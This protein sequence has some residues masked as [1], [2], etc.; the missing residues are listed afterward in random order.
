[1]ALGG[2]GQRSCDGGGRSRAAGRESYGLG[3]GGAGLG[4]DFVRG[5]LPGQHLF[6][7][8]PAH[9]TPFLFAGR[10][11]D[12]ALLLALKGGLIHP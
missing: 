2:T 3:N 12:E 8:L 11:R 10:F 7:H 1:M 6:K 5:A 9:F 4:G